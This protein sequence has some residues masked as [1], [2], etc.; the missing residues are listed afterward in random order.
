MMNLSEEDRGE[1]CDQEDWLV[2]V[3]TRHIADHPAIG[4]MAEAIVE[5]K[6][7]PPMT[8]DQ[9]ADMANRSTSEYAEGTRVEVI[10]LLQKNSR[11]TVD[12]YAGLSDD[13][14]DR[15]G[16]M[17]AFGGGV[18]TGQVAEFVILT[19]AAQF[20]KSLKAAVGE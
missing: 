10:E 6:E 4:K 9:I 19:S 8:T 13:D 1:V 17:P 14:L 12:F 15:R 5:G 2:G 20:L 11:D 16:S 3:T 18:T 7:L